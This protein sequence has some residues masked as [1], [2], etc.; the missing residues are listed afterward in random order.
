MVVLMCVLET[1]S[2]RGVFTR[3]CMALWLEGNAKVAS[4]HDDAVLF[5]SCALSVTPSSKR[6]VVK[7]VLKCYKCQHAA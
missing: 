7:Y 4:Q 5:E 6:R 1:N 2:D 3:P